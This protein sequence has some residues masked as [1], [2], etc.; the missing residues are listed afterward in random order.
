MLEFER[1]KSIVEYLHRHQTATVS[2]LSK[3]LFASEA[4]IRRDLNELERKGLIKRLHGGAVLI[5]EAR[6]EVPLYLREQQNVEGKRQIAQEAAHF[7][8]E[9]QV[10]FLDASSTA[11]FLIRHLQSFQSL[12]I[13]TNG[14]KTAQELSGTGLR[15]YCTGGLLLHNSSAYVGEYAADFVRH[16]NADVFFFS[17]RGLS[18]DG[19]ITDV[20]PEETHLRKVMFEHSTQRIFLCDHTKHGKTYCYNL[21]HLSQIDACITDRS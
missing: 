19:R 4:T 8:K 16:F 1:Q 11:M 10:I 7:L 2:T 17:S 3:R 21:C 15:V 20:S 5:D 12:T 9:G 18:E 14:L 13:V 6:S